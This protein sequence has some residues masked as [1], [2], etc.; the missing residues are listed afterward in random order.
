MFLR[1]AYDV[2]PSKIQQNVELNENLL[3]FNHDDIFSNFGLIV[4]Q[5]HRTHFRKRLLLSANGIGTDSQHTLCKSLMYVGKY[6]GPGIDPWRT[7]HVINFVLELTP[8][9]DTYNFVSLEK[10]KISIIMICWKITNIKSLPYLSRDIKLIN[11][12][13]VCRVTV[14]VSVAYRRLNVKDIYF[15]GEVIHHSQNYKYHGNIWCRW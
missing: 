12:C 1:E 15:N 11:K 5:I 13:Q 3:I 9:Y 6:N 7:P 10:L 8:L 2:C 4:S 14:L